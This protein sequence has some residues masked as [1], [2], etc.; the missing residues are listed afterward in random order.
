MKQDLLVYSDYFSDKFGCKLYFKPE[1]QGPTRSHKDK[2]AKAAIKLAKVAG[3]NK[4]AV[5]SSG[6]QGLSL[7]VEASKQHVSCAICVTDSINPTYLKLFNKYGAR[8]F[9][10]DGEEAKYEDFGRLVSEGY[11]P[12]GVTHEQ[13][14]EGKQMPGV[15]A[16]K[17]ESREITDT[18]GNAPDT[19]VFPTAFADHPE[20]VLRGFIEQYEAGQINAIPKFILVRA[21]ERDGGEATSIATDRTTPYVKD[22]IT[23][24]EGEYVYVN[25]LEMHKAHDE[26]MKVQGWDVELASA[27]SVAGVEKVPKSH[28]QGKKLVVMLTA[29]ADKTG[30]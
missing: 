30:I 14:A 5:I 12:L 16:Y 2:W 17:L 11:F 8:V 25:N 26:I 13:R 23:H 27:A 15:D 18:L 28:L 10:G 1:W 9:I 22:V 4:V 3:A 29:L 7:A 21:N 24:S 6:N 20:G 19:I